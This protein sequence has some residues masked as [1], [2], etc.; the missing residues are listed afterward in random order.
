MFDPNPYRQRGGWFLG[1]THNMHFD[2]HLSN[3]DDVCADPPCA[4]P[5]SISAGKRIENVTI[6]DGT[7]F[8]MP[9]CLGTPCAGANWDQGNPRKIDDSQIYTLASCYPHGNPVDEVCR[10]AG[11]TNLRFIV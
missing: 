1:F 5:L 9:S 11:A 4:Y 8:R 2:I 6:D 7:G 10:T 3:L